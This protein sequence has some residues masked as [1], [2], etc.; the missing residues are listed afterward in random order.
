[1]VSNSSTAILTLTEAAW[2]PVKPAGTGSWLLYTEELH[3]SLSCKWKVAENPM[4]LRYVRLRRGTELDWACRRRAFR[5]IKRTRRRAGRRG[6]WGGGSFRCGREMV[7]LRWIIRQAWISLSIKTWSHLTVLWVNIENLQWMLMT[8]K[9]WLNGLHS[10]ITQPSC[11]RY[12][13][14]KQ[15]FEFSV[16]LA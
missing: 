4:E 10:L 16:F 9:S 7:K 2:W 5:S 11:K 14:Q 3:N 1:M 13:V 12:A 6:G 15:S 8:G